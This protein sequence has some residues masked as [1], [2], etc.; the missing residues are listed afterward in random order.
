MTP[1]DVERAFKIIKNW[2]SAA[3]VKRDTTAEADVN[4]V[5]KVLRDLTG[6]KK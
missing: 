6:R 4:H 5:E 3:R 1:A 2:K